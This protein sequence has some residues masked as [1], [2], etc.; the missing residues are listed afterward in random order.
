[1]FCEMVFATIVQNGHAELAETL[2][3][4]REMLERQK[5]ELA[6]ARAVITDQQVKLRELEEL[7]QTAQKEALHLHEQLTS[8]QRDLREVNREL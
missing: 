4:N 5:T 3:E 7:Y 6:T 1:M 8:A 2:A